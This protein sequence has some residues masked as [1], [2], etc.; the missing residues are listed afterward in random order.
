M[1]EEPPSPPIPTGTEAAERILMAAT[2]AALDAMAD[3]PDFHRPDPDGD[4]E[5]F[6][7]GREIR[8]ALAPV[9]AGWS[10]YHLTGQVLR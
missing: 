4:D 2:L 3:D 10:G 7:L 8:A 9:V 5:A 1:N 6:E